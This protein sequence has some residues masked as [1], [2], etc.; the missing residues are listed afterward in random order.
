M[1]RL[2]IFAAITLGG[3]TQTEVVARSPGNVI[4]RHTRALP[5]RNCS[6]PPRKLVSR[7]S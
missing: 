4:V 6:T 2:A 1:H 7:A 5:P 3:C